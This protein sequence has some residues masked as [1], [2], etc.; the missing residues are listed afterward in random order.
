MLLVLSCSLLVSCSGDNGL[1]PASPYLGTN[2]LLN[3]SFE[4]NGM[5]SLRAWSLYWSDTNT[6]SFSSDVPPNGGRYSVRMNNHF[7]YTGIQTDILPKN[8][9]L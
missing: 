1:G 2:L 6:V 8:S 5:P 4:E 7:G 9:S 3:G